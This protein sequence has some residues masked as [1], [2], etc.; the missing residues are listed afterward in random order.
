MAEN[1][2]YYGDNL[3][4]L[5]RYIKEESVDLI[6]LDPPFNSNANHNVL[7]EDYEG[8]KSAAQAFGLCNKGTYKTVHRVLSVFFAL[9]VALAPLLS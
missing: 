8:S 5:H 1:T 2:L 7:F 9:V 3:D 6:Y 4:I